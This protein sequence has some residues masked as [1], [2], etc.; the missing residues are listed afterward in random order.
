MALDQHLVIT[1]DGVGAVA[2][3]ALRRAVGVHDDVA[4]VEHVTREIREYA[5]VGDL[6]PRPVVVER[7]RHLH[8]HAM[9]AREG[10]TDRFAKTFGLVVTGARTGTRDVTAVILGRGDGLRR[11]IAIDLARGVEQESVDRYAALGLAHAV[12]EQIAQSVDVGVYRLQ[13][14]LAVIDRRSNTRGMDD[15]PEVADVRR[16]RLDHILAHQRE[17]R[18]AL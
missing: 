14:M 3:G 12:I 10:H 8:R 5:T 1:G 7:S 15:V 2:K 9:L 6:E 13:G 17:I 11:W 16:Q 18:I 4:P